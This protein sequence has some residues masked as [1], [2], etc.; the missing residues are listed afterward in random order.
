MSSLWTELLILHGHITDPR[1]LRRLAS[2]K[3]SPPPP[4]ATHAAK[5]PMRWLQRLCLGIGDGL[6]RRQ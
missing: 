2:R 6:L 1:L 5:P 3:P 4:T